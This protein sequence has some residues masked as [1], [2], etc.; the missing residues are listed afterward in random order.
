M[1]E[2][3]NYAARFLHDF[4]ETTDRI[5]QGSVSPLDR[6][7]AARFSMLERSPGSSPMATC[8]SRV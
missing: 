8:G 3:T 4:P 1:V 7:D 5:G 2:G 6:L